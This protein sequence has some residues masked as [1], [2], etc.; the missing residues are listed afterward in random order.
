MRQGEIWL[1]DLNPTIGA[2]I[3][4][5]RPAVIVNNN[6]IGRLPLKIIVPLT[7]WKDKYKAAIWMVEVIP[8]SQNNLQKPSSADCF[9]VRSL[10]ERRFVKKVGEVGAEVKEKMREALLTVMNI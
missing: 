10:S 5:V 6:I 8:D 1:I 2:E 7:D 4:K 3:N 9:Q